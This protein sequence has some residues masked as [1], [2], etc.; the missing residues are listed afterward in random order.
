VISDDASRDGTARIIRERLARFAGAHDVRLR[1]GTSNLGVCRNQNAALE[2]CSGELVVLFEGDDV[3][4][5]DR[6]ARLVAE[7]VRLDR[8]VGALASGIR[9]IRADGSYSSTVVWPT[10]RADAWSMVRHEW[11]VHGCSMAFRRECVSEIGPL[12]RWLMSGDN[13]LW[14]RA[15]FV[16][17]GGLALIGEPLVDYRVHDT[18]VSSHFQIDYSSGKS[19]RSSCFRLRAHEIAL[20]HELRKI[21]VYRDRLQVPDRTLDAAWQALW[22]ESRARAALVSTIASKR[23]LAWLPVAARALRY[24]ALRRFALN[25]ITL[26][27]LP[28]ARSGYRALRGRSGS[29]RIGQR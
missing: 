22:Q 18:N 21:K 16:R 11:S 20:L 26:A 4:A 6:V 29:A 13:G 27:L 3:S 24:P 8:A 5:P 1:A 7:Y 25:A 12:S 17:D 28:W 2:L 23:R 14:L 19:L 10:G 9:L 15:A